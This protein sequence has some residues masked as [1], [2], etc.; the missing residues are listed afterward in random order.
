MPN[1]RLKSR[2]FQLLLFLFA[3]HAEGVSAAESWWNKESPSRKKITL[4]T[5]AAAITD[6]I[7]G[8]ALLIR[9]HDGNFPFANAK[10]DG[11]DLRF[12]AADDKTVLAHHVEKFDGLLN[13]A[14]VWVRVPEVKS[15]GQTVLW[16]YYGNTGPSATSTSDAKATY[17]ADTAL[18]WHFSDNGSA[19]QDA[20]GNG[21]AAEKPGISIGGSYIAGGLRLDGTNPVT[22][23][24]SP[25]LAIAPGGAWTWSAWVKPAALAPDAVLF[26]RAEGAGTLIIGANNGAPFVEVNGSRSPAGAPLTVGTWAHLAV[27]AAGGQ[28]TLF[29]D[30]ESA[31]VLS[32]SLPAL[33]SPA[34]LGGAAGRSGFAGEIDELQIARVARPVGAI[35]LAAIGQAGEKSAKLLTFTS[36]E[37]PKGWLSWLEGGYF[38]II[39]KNLTFDGWL[40]I[41]LCAILGIISWAVMITKAR[42]LSK[43]GRA[44]AVFTELWRLVETDPSVL[45]EGL[46]SK[47]TPAQQKLLRHSPLYRVYHIGAE[48]IA[49]RLALRPD[50][51]RSLSS[52]AIQAI[53]ARLDGG[54]VLETERVNSKIVLLTIA[55]S[56]GP[57]LGL[58]GTVVGVMITFAAVAAAGDVNVNAIAPGI[59]AALLAT[60]AGL[61]VAIPALFGYNYLLARIKSAN[62]ALHVFIDEFTTSM[63]E[64][65][66]GGPA[67]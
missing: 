58:L 67:E 18:V 26:Y 5:A 53:R 3:F 44:N 17:D 13:E 39:L 31:A 43:I 14:L 54:Q 60:V 28:V 56:G 4:D 65:Y 19:P 7:G 24:A 32:A 45:D 15:G 16:L 25:S 23:P 52:R 48:T 46:A 40:V 2:L 35:K 27:V 64:H 38:G 37:A 57:F 29:V 33:N 30:G 41:I 10:S 21:N 1:A 12:V 66:R 22:V 63:A 50:Q 8:T 62:T 59:A 42:Y 49:H 6:P 55:I 9:L 11:A 34:L 47:A 61:G 20:T 51:P 36:D